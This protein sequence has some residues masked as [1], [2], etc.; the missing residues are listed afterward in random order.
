MALRLI[1]GGARSGKSAHAQALAEAEAARR[2]GAPVMIATAE[3]L[4]AEMAERIARHR[5]ERGPAWR[6]RET[7]LEAADALRSLAATDCAVVDCLTLWLNNLMFAERDLEAATEALLC[8]AAE[9]AG[10]VILVTNEVGMSIV[11]E[12]ALAR[13]FRDEAGRMNRR[14]AERADEV[15]VMFAGIPLRLK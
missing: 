9:S 15:V 7:P 11:P 4:D 1:I 13:R 5:A 8:A 6:T 2:G 14:A 10:E 12:N 3:A